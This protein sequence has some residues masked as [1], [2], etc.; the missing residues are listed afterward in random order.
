LLETHLSAC[1]ALRAPHARTIAL[2]S[3]HR[4][5]LDLRNWARA[6]P[7]SFALPVVVSK[8]Q[9]LVFAAWRPDEPVVLDQYGI[10]VPAVQH[11]VQPDV[12]LIPCVAFNIARVRLGYGA[13]YYDRTLAALAP[14]PL[15]LGVAFAAQGCEFEAAAHDI[16]LDAII[17]ERGVV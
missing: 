10:A 1:L 2:Y 7:E 3:P 6:R 16:A 15:A 12:L 14:R 13:G 8:A 17:T 11:V 5:E 9:A 4:G